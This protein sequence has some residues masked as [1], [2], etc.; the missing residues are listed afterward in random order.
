MITVVTFKCQI[1]TNSYVTSGREPVKIYNFPIGGQR[2]YDFDTVNTVF[3]T[4]RYVFFGSNGDFVGRPTRNFEFETSSEWERTRNGPKC[5]ILERISEIVPFRN[6]IRQSWLDVYFLRPIENYFAGKIPL[7][8]L[9]RQLKSPIF[10]QIYAGSNN[11]GRMIRS[12]WIERLRF[13]QIFTH[14]YAT[15]PSKFRIIRGLSR[16]RY[17]FHDW[18]YLLLNP[19][20]NRSDSRFWLI[21]RQNCGQEIGQNFPTGYAGTILTTRICQPN[22]ESS[23]CELRNR[24][25][26]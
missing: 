8:A 20:T 24:S 17:D 6:R 7:D 26:A 18:T 22:G 19:M 21:I 23:H 16:C 1:F 4:K 25:K 13:W 9:R 2:R 10:R 12:I 14:F 5:E 11:P 15:N 3:A